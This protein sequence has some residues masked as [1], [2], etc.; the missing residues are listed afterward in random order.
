MSNHSPDISPF[1]DP[2]ADS[3]L[4]RA[5]YLPRLPRE[6]YRGSAVVFWTLPVAQR[7]KGWLTHEFH[8]AFR[9]MMLH[10]AAREGLLCPVYCLMPDH[11]HLLWLGLHD[12]TD[13]RNAMA[14][15]RTHLKPSLI[16]HK[17]QHQPHDH[18]LR[19]HQRRRGAFSM[20]CRYVLENPV[21]ASL[22]ESPET[23]PYSG[24]IVP[25]YPRLHPAVN[26][27][28]DFWPV[29]WKVYTA[30]RTVPFPPPS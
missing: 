6:F 25:G 12:A 8:A 28:E 24:C 5:F 21:R 1:R 2:E 11:L 19:E 17:F 26:P 20:V 15:L 29:F 27:R 3:G 10:A 30:M 16:P 23:W 9:E 14:F 13:Q 18:A 4:D 22:A 7:G